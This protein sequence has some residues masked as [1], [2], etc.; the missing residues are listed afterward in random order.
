[1]STK[2]IIFL[3]IDGVLNSRPNFFEYWWWRLT[4]DIKKKLWPWL[5]TG[6]IQNINRRHAR[7]LE[8]L[9]RR[10][11]AFIVISSTWRHTFPKSGQW[12]LLLG[13]A[14]APMASRRVVGLTGSLGPSKSFEPVRGNEIELWLREHGCYQNAE[15]R[16]I[17]LDDDSDMTEEQKAS[18]FVHVKNSTG[19]RSKHVRKAIQLLGKREKDTPKFW[20]LENKRSAIFT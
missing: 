1:M 4:K 5:P 8:Q 3:D 11:G 15:V 20:D 14:G 2:K 10:T 13:L 18:H 9:V 17:I 7:R 16:Y 19:L 12:Y 6:G